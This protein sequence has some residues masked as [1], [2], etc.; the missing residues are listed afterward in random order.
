MTKLRQQ[1][2]Q[3]AVEPPR[4]AED[5]SSLGFATEGSS[6]R[7]SRAAPRKTL[8]QGSAGDDAG[9]RQ[10]GFAADEEKE[11]E[12][13]SDI[14]VLH[15]EELNTSDTQHKP[16]RSAWTPASSAPPSKVPFTCLCCKGFCRTVPSQEVSKLIALAEEKL[17][18]KK[19]AL[20]RRRKQLQRDREAWKVRLLGL[21]C[22]KSNDQRHATLTSTGRCAVLVGFSRP[23]R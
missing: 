7:E 16:K 17:K 8:F 4:P 13:D 20:L 14:E 10:G 19:R 5:A 11:E 6:A 15:H 23:Q 12:E 2:S 3:Q 9:T 18:E 22:E 21:P 1:L